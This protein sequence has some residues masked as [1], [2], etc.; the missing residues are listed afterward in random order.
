MLLL[1][2]FKLSVFSLFIFLNIFLL[3]TKALLFPLIFLFKS[4]LLLISGLSFLFSFFSF[5][6]KILKLSLI[7]ILFKS[8]D[9]LFFKSSFFKLFSLFLSNNS[10]LSFMLRFTI[11]LI[12]LKLFLLKE[13]SNCLLILLLSWLIILY[14]LLLVLL[15]DFLE[16][17][18]KLYLSLEYSD[19]LHIPIFMLIF[20][21]LLIS[22]FSL[23]FSLIFELS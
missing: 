8:F 23:L 19:L 5:F 18:T 7:S 9:N 12:S 22:I 20:L 10:L 4:I 17:E 2:I 21:L 3:P 14:I 15:F 6:S 13:S 1:I 16:E 11:S